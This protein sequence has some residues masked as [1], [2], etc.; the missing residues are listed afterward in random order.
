MV[1]NRTGLLSL[2]RSNTGSQPRPD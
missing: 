2:P 1:S